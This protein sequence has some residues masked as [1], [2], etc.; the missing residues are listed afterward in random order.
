MKYHGTHRR[1]KPLYQR[2]VVRSSATLAVAAALVA[3]PLVNSAARASGLDCAA[4]TS[5]ATTLT[6]VEQTFTT[7]VDAIKSVQQSGAG[8]SL[9]GPIV[10]HTSLLNLVNQTIN[11]AV[12]EAGNCVTQTDP[13]CA[14]I[15]QAA[16]QEARSIET[17]ATT[18]VGG[19]N[20]VC[21]Q[22]EQ[23]TTGEVSALVTLANQCVGGQDA[24]CNELLGTVSQ[25]VGEAVTCAAG[26]LGPAAPSTLPDPI[27]INRGGGGGLPDLTVTCQQVKDA[28]AQLVAGCES[29][30]TAGCGQ[31]IVTVEKSPCL[32]STDQVACAQA[33]AA[34]PAVVAP[35]DDPGTIFPTNELRGTI[36]LGS[37]LGAAGVTVSFYVDPGMES[38]ETVTPDLLGTATTDANGGYI[39]TITPDAHATS[40]AADNGGVL[41]V[42]ISATVSVSIPGSAAPPILVIANGETPL[43]LG[44]SAQYWES[45]PPTLVLTPASDVD[46]STTPAVDVAD[47]TSPGVDPAINYLPAVPSTVPTFAGV[48][49]GDN[50]FLVNGIDYRNAVPVD[51]PGTDSNGC[52]RPYLS[53]ATLI[54]KP[55]EK[56]DIIGET[57]AYYDTKADFTYGTTADS[58]LETGFSNTFRNWFGG[59]YSTIRNKSGGV[60]INITNAGPYYGHQQL[61]GFLFKAWK[62]KY[63]CYDSDKIYYR[64]KAGATKCMFDYHEGK[65]I[66]KYD[67]G[68]RYAYSDSKNRKILQPSTSTHTVRL[69]IDNG[70]AY[71]YTN[72]FS[73][74]G[75][76][77]GSASGHSTNVIQGITSGRK[78]IEHDIWGN[79]KPIQDGPNIMYSY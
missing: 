1:R 26:P 48:P 32:N 63:Q 10:V 16:T 22:L 36:V 11:Q 69:Y 30:A 64:Y 5:P 65:D 27:V 66:L 4:A 79:N 42:L 47:P 67:G 75:F 74:W 29:G 19:T 6:C 31:V 70:K 39:T 13:T 54:G 68:E 35:D 59:G 45:Q 38:T 25:L 46:L 28:A 55:V 3:P 33:T 21:T 51:I 62:I 41:N 72:S 73:I 43:T 71:Y 24:T 14:L 57:H 37:G 49:T 53:D 23:L 2:L 34:P 52:E 44:G 58:T 12:A 20:A 7:A 77:G 17:M 76:Q 15:V 18:C 61:S 56:N 8:V 9:P 60:G 78:Q 50:V 40:L